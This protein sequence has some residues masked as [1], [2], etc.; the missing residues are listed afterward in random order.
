MILTIS[1]VMKQ[2]TSVAG[3]MIIAVTTCHQEL[4]NTDCATVPSSRSTFVLSLTHYCD[5][6]NNLLF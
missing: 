1:D 2:R 6:A 3:S 5:A 4:V